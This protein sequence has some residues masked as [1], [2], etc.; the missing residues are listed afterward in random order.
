MCLHY[1]SKQLVVDPYACALLGLYLLH[2]VFFLQSVVQV[3]HLEVINAI[4]YHY[5]CARFLL[6]YYS[7]TTPL[8]TRWALSCRQ[9][10]HYPISINAARLMSHI[11][12]RTSTPAFSFLHKFNL[13][14]SALTF[15]TSPLFSYF[16]CVAMASTALYSTQCHQQHPGVHVVLSLRLD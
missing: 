8:H 16:T 12:T 14:L 13:P 4:M 1:N 6:M 11:G 2:G 9:H 7:W 3:L 5:R 15:D 10:L